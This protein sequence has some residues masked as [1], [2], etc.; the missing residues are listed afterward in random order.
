[1]ITPR[2]TRLYN[3]P[4]LPTFQRTIAGC[5]DGP[6]GWNRRA[7]VVLVSP[8]VSTYPLVS[9]LLTHLFLKRLERVT[10]P[11]VVGGV[12]V[13]AGVALVAFGRG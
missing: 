8:L 9:I 11:T 10:M 1:M 4:D 6:T 5:L 2:Q 3:T 13:A 12:L 7:S